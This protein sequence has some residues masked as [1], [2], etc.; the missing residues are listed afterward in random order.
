MPRGRGPA[1]EFISSAILTYMVFLLAVVANRGAE[2]TAEAWHGA[3]V[4]SDS[5]D[6]VALRQAQAYLG[7]AR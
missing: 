1:N 7:Q 4:W 5:Q 6:T 3:G 2:M